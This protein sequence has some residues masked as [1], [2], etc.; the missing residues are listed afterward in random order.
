MAGW[1]GDGVGGG[2][3]AGVGRGGGGV[4]GLYC[5]VK[6]FTVFAC[7]GICVT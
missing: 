7:E 6:D 1:W 4:C 3:G 2:G 5:C